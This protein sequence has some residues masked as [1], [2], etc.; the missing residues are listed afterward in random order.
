MSDAVIVALITGGLTLIGTIITIMA[1][2]HKTSEENRVSQARM[3]EKIEHLTEE[4][5]RHNNFAERIPTVEN[6]VK[7]INHRLDM[8]EKE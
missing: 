7:N 5:R 1:T 4:V 6:E 8:L 3:E 2:N